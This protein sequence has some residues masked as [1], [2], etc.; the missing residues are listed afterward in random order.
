MNVELLGLLRLAL[1]MIILKEVDGL[2]LWIIDFKAIFCSLD[3][4]AFLPGDGFRHISFELTTYDA[5]C[6]LSC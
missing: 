2:R 1:S 4:L 6:E 5:Y 3:G